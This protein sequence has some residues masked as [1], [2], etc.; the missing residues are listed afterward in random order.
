MPDNQRFKPLKGGFLGCKVSKNFAICKHFGQIFATFSTQKTDGQIGFFQALTNLDKKFFTTFATVKKTVLI[1]L[2]I[3]LCLTAIAQKR[4]GETRYPMYYVVDEN[5]DTTFVDSLDP[6]WC[7]PKGTRLK[8]G[9]WRRQYKLVYNFNKVYPYALAGR[10][11]MRQVDSVLAHDVSK[12][13]QRNAY[14]H[15]VMIEL[16]DIFGSDIRHMTISQGVVLMRLVDRECGIPPFEI[17]KQYRSGF[18]ANFWQM[19]ARIFGQNLKKR[20]DPKG[21]DAALEELVQIWNKGHWDSFYY[22]VFFDYPAKTV[23]KRE[24]LQS[25]VQSREERRRNREAEEKSLMRKGLE[26]AK[27]FL[28]DES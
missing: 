8:K 27:E 7:F 18:S 13:S 4:K 3:L 24:R 23:I 6:V 22:A 21:E 14:T 17:I 12:R 25:T 2:G 1:I 5:G 28:K 19:I 15:D 16:F 10:T 20:Y 9:D 26:E 11:M